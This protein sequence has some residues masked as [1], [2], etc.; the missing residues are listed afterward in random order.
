MI[1]SV[2]PLLGLLLDGLAGVEHQ[3]KSIVDDFDGGEGDEDHGRVNG[4]RVPRRRRPLHGGENKQVRSRLP[5]Y[6]SKVH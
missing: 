2:A 6:G 5:S 1:A 4:P 3:V